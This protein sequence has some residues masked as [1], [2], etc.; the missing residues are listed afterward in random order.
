MRSGRSTCSSIPGAV[1]NLQAPPG[2]S[3]PAGPPL[4]LCQQLVLCCGLGTGVS[5]TSRASAMPPRA[6]LCSVTRA[7]SSVRVGHRWLREFEKQRDASRECAGESNCP[8]ASPSSPSSF[9]PL[10]LRPHP[11]PLHPARGAAAGGPARHRRP[12]L[13]HRFRHRWHGFW[14]HNIIAHHDMSSQALDDMICEARTAG[15]S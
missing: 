4:D 11:P 10:G 13:R 5:K 8:S 12:P 6:Y 15:T 7:N 9:P 3:R 1:C 2:I 14:C